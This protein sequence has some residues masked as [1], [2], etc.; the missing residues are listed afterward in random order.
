MGKAD[1]V[2]LSL[3]RGLELL[4]ILGQNRNGMKAIELQH[5]LEIPHSS[6]YRILRVLTDKGYARQDAVDG[7]F[8]LSA[9]CMALGHLARAGYPLVSDIQAVLREVAHATGQ[10]SEFAIPSGNWQLMILETWQSEKTPVRV[11]SRPGLRMELYH[12][13]AHGLCFLAFDS[14]RKLRDYLAQASPKHYDLEE[15]CAQWRK[16]GYVWDRPNAWNVCRVSAP[17]FNPSSNPRRL[18]GALGVVGDIKERVPQQIARWGR[19]LT[20]HTRKL[21]RTYA[22]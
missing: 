14:E 3:E 20:A 10:M 4:S 9:E 1:S 11:R 12:R 22:R 7:R 15:Q 21:E 2:A 19:I 17:V 16:L 13:N 8:Y 18:I 6:L 5:V